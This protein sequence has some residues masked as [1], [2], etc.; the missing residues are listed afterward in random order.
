MQQSWKNYLWPFISNQ[1]ILFLYI[2]FICFAFGHS[3]NKKANRLFLNFWKQSFFSYFFFTSGQI[4]IRTYP[5]TVAGL[6]MPEK[7]GGLSSNLNLMF[8]K[9]WVRTDISD[10]TFSLIQ[11]LK[12]KLRLFSILILVN[13]NLFL[14]N[15]D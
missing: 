14:M 8:F 6:K 1:N 15:C 12:E 3:P 9:D 2:I 10:A 13:T 7:C 4:A 11:E 5:T